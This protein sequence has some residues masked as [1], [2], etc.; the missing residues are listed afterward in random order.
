MKRKRRDSEES[1]FAKCTRHSS[2]G[3]LSLSSLSNETILDI[4][5][6]LSFNDLCQA[7]LLNH[8]LSRLAT[9]P[10]LWKI[11]YLRD[12]ATR[13]PLVRSEAPESRFKRQRRLGVLTTEDNVKRNALDWKLRY[14]IRY[15]WVHGRCRTTETSAVSSAIDTSSNKHVSTPSPAVLNPLFSADIKSLQLDDSGPYT[16]RMIDSRHFMISDVKQ[17]HLV[18]AGSSM[19]PARVIYSSQ[20]SADIQ[21]YNNL[22]ALLTKEQK[23]LIIDLSRDNNEHVVSYVGLESDVSQLEMRSVPGMTLVSLITVDTGLVD[24]VVRIQE[25]AISNKTRHI[26][27]IRTGKVH[28]SDNATSSFPA[29]INGRFNG[30]GKPVYEHPFLLIPVDKR[31]AVFNVY[32]TPSVLDI[33]YVKTLHGYTAEIKSCRLNRDVLF[34]VATGHAAS[35][36]WD[37]AVRGDVFGTQIST[38]NGHKLSSVTENRHVDE[39][40]SNSILDITE[41]LITIKRDRFS[42]APR[43][44]AEEIQSSFVV[45]DFG[46]E[47]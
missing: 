16:M 38:E 10:L 46:H 6:H 35:R 12:Y 3:S 33:E 25:I 21:F 30:L 34:V 26:E 7:Q 37:M 47:S 23:L 9:D 43:D 5:K 41:R 4:F 8:R 19:S 15:N 44:P 42:Q 24:S 40:E 2:E 13:R 17:F 18:R 20:G 1:S 11:L 32:S 29:R 14:K 22:L 31:I 27:H 28:F 39:I 36:V 45:H